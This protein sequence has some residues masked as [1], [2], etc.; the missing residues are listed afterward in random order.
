MPPRETSTRA[1]ILWVQP[2]MC[3]LGAK[4]LDGWLEVTASEGLALWDL[5]ACLFSSRRGRKEGQEAA[6]GVLV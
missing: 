2:E 1:P 4:G 5:G 6:A 3:K